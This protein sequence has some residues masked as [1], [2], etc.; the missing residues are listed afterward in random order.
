MSGTALRLYN[1]Q[2][3]AVEPFQPRDPKRVSMYACG[4]T[5]YNYAHIGNFR[6]FLYGD[7]LRRVLRFFGFEVKSVMNFTDVD[8]KTIRGSRE[9]G[10]PLGAFTDKFIAAF[11]EDM[12]TL[13]IDPQDA[14]PR[15]TDYIP[16]MIA[17]VETLL[18]KG[19]AY[20]SEDGSVYFRIA[21][22]PDYG[23]LSRLDKDGLK[24]GAR[25]AQDEYQKEAYG[26]FVLWK[27]WVAEDG[28]VAWDSPWGKGR[29]GW[30]I[31]CSAMSMALLGPELDLHCAGID[32]LFPHHE[33][34][35]AQSEGA[36]GKPFVRCWGHCAHLMVD[37]QK[38]SKS[39]GNLF[40]VRDVLARGYTGRELRYVLLGTHYRQTLNFTWEGVA[41]ARQALGRIDNWLGRWQ[42]LPAASF[43]GDAAVGAAFLE[44]FTAAFADDL[45]ISGA[46]GHFFDFI[47]ETN[48]LIDQGQP[49]PDLPAI[50]KRVDSVLGLGEKAVE[51][52]VEIQSL[53]DARLAAR[54][55]K[56]WKKSDELRG[57]LDRLGWSVRD[58]AKGQELVKK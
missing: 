15:A 44:K 30:H 50:W 32:L 36:T 19:L 16:Q 40:T 14:Q 43:Q 20:R 29:P 46:L 11:R 57:E 39:L 34:E 25:V 7:L 28:D 17:L 48:R 8:D 38:M 47:H 45:N 41:A 18:E 31:E 12:A 22:L 24:A 4:P 33:N 37:G 55:A 26:D 3:R 58:S 56:D 6:S 53:A 2:S 23:K 27:A 5:V 49:L 51:V 9:A 54:Q 13:R 1:S 21:A 42:A 35:I 52:P 10:V